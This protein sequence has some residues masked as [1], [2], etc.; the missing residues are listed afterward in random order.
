MKHTPL[1][2]EIINGKIVVNEEEAKKIR[3]M[4]M[5]YL[6][7]GSYRAAAKAVGFKLNPTSVKHIF[8]N[9]KYLGGEH[10]PAIIDRKTFDAAEAERINREKA[11]GI[12][13]KRKIAI[14]I[15]CYIGFSMPDIDKKFSDPIKQAEYGYGL[16]RNEVRG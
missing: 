3:T 4:L 8:Q 10:Y 13:R 5:V 14:Q 1:G 11:A 16:I 9:E 7:G 15:K 2:Y 6:F 12:K